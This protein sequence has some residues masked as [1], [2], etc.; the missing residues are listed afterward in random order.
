MRPYLILFAVILG[1][2]PLAADPPPPVPA[3][4]L[5]E[6]AKSI[7][8]RYR[9]RLMEV[10]LE[11]PDR[12]ERRMGTRVVYEAEYLTPG[13]NRLTLRLDG[14]TGAFLSVEGVGQTEARIRK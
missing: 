14:D 12:E 11:E 6:I 9:G 10:E 1:A 13:D 8:A 4:D 7:A 5:P 2:S 3:L